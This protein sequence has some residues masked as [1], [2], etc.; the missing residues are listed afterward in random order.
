MSFSFDFRILLE[1]FVFRRQMMKMRCINSH[2]EVSFLFVV[3]AAFNSVL[4]SHT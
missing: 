1:F 3:T 4:L 2:I